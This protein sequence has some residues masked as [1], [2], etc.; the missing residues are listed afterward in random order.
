MASEA[1]FVRALFV[2]ALFVRA[3]FVRALGLVCVT[4]AQEL[5]STR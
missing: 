3:L 4:S 5:R 1:L 2:R